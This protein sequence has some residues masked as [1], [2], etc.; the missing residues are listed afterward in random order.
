MMLAA[1]VWPAFAQDNGG[2]LRI[3]VTDRLGL[4]ISCAVDLAILPEE[5]RYGPQTNPT[6]PP[7]QVD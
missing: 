3:R 5:M 7:Q 1:V 4:D 6:G 2:Q